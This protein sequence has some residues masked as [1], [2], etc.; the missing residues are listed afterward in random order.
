MYMLVV[1]SEYPATVF[2]VL[3]SGNK[4]VRITS[5]TLFDLLLLK[6]SNQFYQKKIKIESKG[7]EMAKL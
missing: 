4:T 6:L 2:S 1:C 7:K 3:E 5:D